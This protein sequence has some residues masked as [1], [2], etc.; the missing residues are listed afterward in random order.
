D[1]EVEVI[2][3]DLVPRH[4]AGVAGDFA[5]GVIGV[6]DLVDVTLTQAVFVAVLDETARGVDHKD[7][8]LVA[9][10]DLIENDDRGGDTRAVEEVGRQANDRLY[11]AAL[12]DLFAQL[13]FFVATEQD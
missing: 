2:P 9:S 4:K 3:L 5:L 7:R 6:D 8:T 13:S 11:I 12:E 10:L 1:V